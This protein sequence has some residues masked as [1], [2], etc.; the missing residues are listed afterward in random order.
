M[1]HCNILPT[2]PATT[3]TPV[4]LVLPFL[5]DHSDTRGESEVDDFAQ[6]L[7]HFNPN[8]RATHDFMLHLIS[9]IIHNHPQ[10]P[11]AIG[12]W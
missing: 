7:P 4:V 10:S 12:A 1:L 8:H 9:C 2:T 11:A 6:S 3:S 5:L